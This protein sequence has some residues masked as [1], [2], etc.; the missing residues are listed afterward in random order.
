M[1]ETKVIY[2]ERKNMYVGNCQVIHE[3]VT[4]RRPQSK[5]VCFAVSG[6][7]RRSLLHTAC[8]CPYCNKVISNK[9]NL[10][11][12]ILDKH[13]VQTERFPCDLCGRVYST[14]HSLATH[15]STVHRG[16]RTTQLSS[17]QQQQV[18][19]PAQQQDHL[20][21]AIRSPTSSAHN[22][23]STLPATSSSLKVN[24]PLHIDNSHPQ[25]S[26]C[27]TLGPMPV[28]SQHHLQPQHQQ[29]HHLHPSS[30]IGP[31]MS[32]TLSTLLT[33]PGPSLAEM[34]AQMPPA[35]LEGGP[36]HEEVQAM[37]QSVVQSLPPFASFPKLEKP[38][39]EDN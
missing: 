27:Q 8:V 15:N 34:A 3:R 26:L 2:D 19:Q 28:E 7:G 13:T 14:K 11:T 1:V 4:V 5:D 29:P 25:P 9:Y 10:K 32:S 17:H 22:P 31:P 12:H 20:T 38:S 6:G 35:P 24:P 33:Q 39:W 30:N 37:A 16:D 21:L 23:M 18:L 36:S